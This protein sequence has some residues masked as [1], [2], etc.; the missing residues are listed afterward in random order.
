M[1]GSLTNKKYMRNEIWSLISFAGAPSWFITFSPADNMHPISLYYADTKEEFTPELRG[2]DDRYRLI[3]E[4]PVAGARFFDM[5]VR[6]FIKHVL[7]VKSNHTGLYGNTEAYYGTVEQQ[8]RLTLHIHMLLWLRGSLSPQ[9]IRDRLMDP[10]SDFQKA[11]VE[12]LESVH[13][14]EF[15]TGTM[16]EVKAQVAEKSNNR[17]YKDP[18][19][20]L[21]EM[22]PPICKGEHDI[23]SDYVCRNCNNLKSW[24]VQFKDTV[25]DLILHSNV[26]DCGRYRSGNEIVTQKNRPSCINKHGK[27]RARFP[28]PV[29]DCTEIDPQTGALNVKKGEAWINTLTPVVTYLL[30][31]NT[32]ITSLLSGTSIK[33]IVAYISDYITK[34]GLKTYSIFDT[35]RSVFDRNTEMLGS[36]MKTKDKARKLITQIT[37][38]LTA[39]L[40]IG[41]PMA[42]LYL[43]GNPD[44]YTSHRFAPV[45]WKNYVRQVL[46][47]WIPEDNLDMDVDAEKVMLWNL[48]G[49]VIG[50]STVHDYIYRPTCYDDVNLYEWIQCAK[51]IKISYQDD[52]DDINSDDELNVIDDDNTSIEDQQL[53]HTTS[54]IEDLNVDFDE[55]NIGDGDDFVEID[56]DDPDSDTTNSEVDERILLYLK[57]HPLYQTHY[58]EFDE[59]NKNV[60]PN[61]VGG[62]LPR[63]DRGDRDYYCTTM[64]TLFKPWRSGKDLKDEA[65]SWDQAFTD[66]EFSE[67]EVQIMNNFNLRYECL[68]ARD[69][70]SAQLRQGTVHNGTCPKFMTLDMIE[71]L[72]NNSLINCDDFD[73][74]YDAQDDATYDPNTYSE[75]GVH[76]RLVKTQMDVT[77]N[78]IRNVGWLDDCPDGPIDINTTPLQIDNNQTASQWKSVVQ[79]RR[80]ELLDERNQHVFQETKSHYK[81]YAD[82]SEN[83]VMI[84]DQSYFMINFRAQNQQAQK[85][86]DATVQK[87][88]LN[89]EQE[90]AFRIIANHSSCSN[91][92]QL[93][94][95]IAGMAGTGKSQVLKAVVDLFKLANESHRYIVLGPTGTSAALQNG[96]TYHYFLGINPN[97]SRKNEA[98]SIAQLKARLEGVNYIFIDEVSMLSCHDLYKISAKLAKAMNVY[99]LP[100][101]GFNIIFAGDF[102]QLPPVGGAALYSGAVGTQIHSGLTPYA[103]ETTIGKALWHQI[104]TVVI[105]RENMRQKS[106]TPDD[107]LFRN[108]LVNM[109][110]GK[111]T[112]EDVRFLRSRIAG[113][114]LDQPNVASKIFRN[115]PIICGM[116]SQK[117]QI[118]ILGCE[119]FAS[120]TNQRL[121]NFYSIDKWSRENTTLRKNKG[122]S[123][124]KVLHETNDIDPDVQ[125]EIWKVRHGATDNV[126]GKL[127]LCVGMPV[128]MR[129][130]DATELCITNGQEGFVSGWQSSK[131][132]H[133]KRVLNILFIKLNNP[134][135]LVQIPG[136]PDNVVPIVRNTKT[137]QCVFPSDHKESI[138]RQQVSVLPNFAMTAHAAQGKTR[139]YNVVHLNSCF[140]HMAYYSSLSRSA[141][142]AG[143]V[144]IQGFDSKVITR[145]CSGYL[146]QEF[147]EQELLDEITKLRYK[148]QLPTYI[149]PGTRSAMI[150]DFQLWKGTDYVPSQTH[151]ALQWSPSD[152]LHLISTVNYSSWQIVDQ[153]KSHDK[154]KDI[155]SSFVSAKGS[156]FVNHKKH[157]L[158]S[159]STGS[160]PPVKKVRLSEVPSI[161]L[162]PLGLI[163]DKDN[164]SCGYDALL[165]ILFDIWKD[166]P[167]IWS[168]VLRSINRH[169]ALLSKGF[170]KISKGSTTFEQVRNTWRD[171]LNLE[172]PIMYPR[173][174]HGIDVAGLAED[175]LK[176]TESIGSSQHQCYRCDYTDNPINDKLTYV[177]HADNSTQHST[178]TWIN[179]LSKTTHKRCPNCNYR[180]KQ[181]IFYNKVPN[182]VILEYPMRNIRT[183]HNLEIQTDEGD[184]QV[185]QLRGL[186][187]HGGYHF[188]SR[189]VSAEQDMWYHDGINTGKICIRDGQLGISTD[190]KLKVCRGKELV[191]ACYAL[192]H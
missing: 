41:G 59:N 80:Q 161:A 83:N 39:K 28:R 142:A 52:H 16:D 157:T 101:G 150:Q 96:S 64:L 40:E 172:N 120:D 175:M 109:R 162:S 82:H 159:A 121:T 176:V 177:L 123:K 178:N 97:T 168:D 100:F 118:N 169:C 171:V 164:Y 188:T 34:P 4:N 74:D 126:A 130:N 167:K 160:Q 53:G 90:R 191:L 30:R 124:N 111:C 92:E 24:W 1:K 173:G 50:R 132:G 117:D 106:Q 182:I 20:T 145:G 91:V 87:F 136:L 166:K 5:M 89:K 86:I 27:C 131:A 35:I 45:Y 189:I 187:Y 37:N 103:Q 108:A 51:R 153:R 69:D 70:F 73:D 170:D 128:I 158:D 3:A 163:W 107:A 14:G 192:K 84:I 148:G 8:G 146:R 10:A 114:Q 55:L 174:T 56:F 48:D 78:V 156:I 26:H 180:M 68:D 77:E 85:M 133:G 7:G 138:E 99:D 113:N 22:P 75:L 183:S 65:E 129:N 155:N 154:S 134:P 43:L 116:H 81:T 33:A 72:D 67:R 185:L 15:M 38:A 62:S 94:M 190:D 141:S 21:P 147:R 88:E 42:A 105:L 184:Q 71:D 149:E 44:H 6:L 135:K 54:S 36:S 9:E 115:V 66:H 119:R 152:P 2:Y 104:T 98:T 60:V 122:Y 31:C 186:V 181:V 151:T 49:K 179:N 140:N 76:G 29:F 139:P 46:T 144:I 23:T 143:T 79:S 95:Y 58:V 19:Q 18:T 125:R 25:D 110:Y 11:F 57:D 63:R 102:A 61:F 13:I 47:A 112:P 127:S 12:Y 93:K 32:D 17:D 137:V 165:V